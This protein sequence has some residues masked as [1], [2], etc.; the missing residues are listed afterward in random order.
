MQD[1]VTEHDPKAMG[2]LAES[3]I[4]PA[5]DLVGLVKGG[6][7]RDEIGQLLSDLT[8]EQRWAFPVIL[9]AMVDDERTPD[10]LLSWVTF[11]EYGRSYGV[12]HTV[13]PRWR[14]EARCGTV[15]SLRRH[16]LLGEDC[17]TCTTAETARAARGAERR[18]RSRRREAA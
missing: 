2:A 3:L 17:E 6:G 8:D 13:T 4:W 11:S 14:V 18:E 5:I 10:E 16:D 15:E 1:A 12:P 7:D 9:A